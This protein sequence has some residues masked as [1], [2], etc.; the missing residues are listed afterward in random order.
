MYGEEMTQK[1]FLKQL[2][3]AYRDAPEGPAKRRAEEDVLKHYNYLVTNTVE[4]FVNIPYGIDKNDLL[5]AGQLGL[6]QALTHYNPETVVDGKA[7]QFVT[8]AI[9]AIRTSIAKCIRE[10]SWSK[11]A[12][13]HEKAINLA[14]AELQEKLGRNP[15]I[16]ELAEH[17]EVTEERATDMINAC[18]NNKPVYMHQ[19]LK[20]SQYPDD[21]E[22]G[23]II[24]S[25]ELDHYDRAVQEEQARILVSLADGLRG[26]MKDIA[27][28]LFQG[29]SVNDISSMLGITVGR[30]GMAVAAVRAR[31]YE[32]IVKEGHG[33][34]FHEWLKPITV[35]SKPGRIRPR[36]RRPRFGL[37]MY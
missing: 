2:I 32:T 1:E 8:Y 10:S 5:L 30:A 11:A 4:R 16:R 23:D 21:M 28:L 37:M 33:E 3:Q 14:R 24:P 20:G 29:Y 19:T 35:S 7:V 31:L 13:D 9:S 18:G 17:L 34:L 27:L 36:R 25:K 6:W 15:N 12:A 22:V 26:Q